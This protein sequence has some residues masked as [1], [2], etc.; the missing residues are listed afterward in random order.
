VSPALCKGLGE[1]VWERGQG[2]QFFGAKGKK[3]KRRNFKKIFRVF[4][5]AHSPLHL[6]PDLFNSLAPSPKTI[7]S[8]GLLR[9]GRNDQGV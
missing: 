1:W 2:F 7:I 9:M 4:S 3:G 6:L 5:F 8:S